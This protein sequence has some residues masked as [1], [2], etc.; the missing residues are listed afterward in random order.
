MPSLVSDNFADLWPS[1][2]WMRDPSSFSYLKHLMLRK[3]SLRS[4]EPFLWVWEN[5]FMFED[6]L[7]LR[8]FQKILKIKSCLFR[9]FVIYQPISKQGEAV[10]K[11]RLL[12][13]IQ[14]ESLSGK[15]VM[16][17][18]PYKMIKYWEKLKI[19]ILQFWD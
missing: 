12:F 5:N 11:P 10:C 16:E 2:E 1:S 9:P 8:D 17:H 4:M 13:L 14:K 15:W 7:A 19:K 18:S 3:D 6:T